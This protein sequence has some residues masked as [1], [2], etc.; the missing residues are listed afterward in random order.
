MLEPI[1]EPITS[2]ERRA[3]APRRPA[4]AVASRPRCARSPC[5]LVEFTWT[6]GRCEA[7]GPSMQRRDLERMSANMFSR[8]GK[9]DAFGTNWEGACDP[10]FPRLVE[11]E[12]RVDR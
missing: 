5:S 2:V 8:I 7:S 3:G 12:I 9:H 6:G 1:R 11:I 10:D 4:L